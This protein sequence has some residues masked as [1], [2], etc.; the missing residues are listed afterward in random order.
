MQRFLPKQ[1]GKRVKKIVLFKI[2]EAEVLS[3]SVL[4]IY[5]IFDQ[6]YTVVRRVLLLKSNRQF[7]ECKIV[8]LLEQNSIQLLKKQNRTV[9]PFSI[10]MISSF[11]HF[12]I[13]RGTYLY[14][15]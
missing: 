14:K 9:T 5:S 6:P 11:F 2:K 15:I 10:S 4:Q 3:K 7:Q 12:V 8:N 1:P 13:A